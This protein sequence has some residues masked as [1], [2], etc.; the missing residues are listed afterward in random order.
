MATQPT[1]Y[2]EWATNFEQQ[3]V[4]L[5]GDGVLV[6]VNNKEEPTEEWKLSGEKFRENL[7]RQYVNYNFDLIS[8]WTTHLNEGLVGDF[9]I[10]PTSAT[11]ATVEARFKGT[12]ADRGVDTIAGQSVKLFEK[13]A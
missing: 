9:K 8:Q 5:E 6:V 12:W 7:P 4:D 10:M 13:I 2:P 11:Q 3:I 1:V